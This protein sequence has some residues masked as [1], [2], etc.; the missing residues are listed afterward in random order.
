MDLLASLRIF[1]TYVLGINAE[2][3][4]I[5]VQYRPLWEGHLF[6]CLL[7]ASQR[8]MWSSPSAYQSTRRLWVFVFTLPVSHPL[9]GWMDLWIS[10]PV[11]L[12][13]ILNW[14]LCYRLFVC[15]CNARLLGAVLFNEPCSFNQYIYP[16][17]RLA[18]WPV[19]ATYFA[20]NEVSPTNQLP[21]C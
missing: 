1:P 17:Y 7:L 9:R 14:R 13:N 21:L 8:K 16:E 2:S 20:G 15:F 5:S 10:C 3:I 6:L 11:V 19:T 18:T 12:P 4:G